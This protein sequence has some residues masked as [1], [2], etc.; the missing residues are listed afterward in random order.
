MLLHDPLKGF[1]VSCLGG[2]DV[3][4]FGC[5]PLFGFC[6]DEQKVNAGG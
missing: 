3:Q 2:A 6:L 4:E 1:H 5:L